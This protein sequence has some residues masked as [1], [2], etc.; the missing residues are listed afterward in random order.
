MTYD[1]FRKTMA[2]RRQHPRGSLDHQYLTRTA[3]KMVW[4]MWGI[5][6]NEWSHK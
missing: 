2:E 4:L 1:A 6:A 5:P 3:R